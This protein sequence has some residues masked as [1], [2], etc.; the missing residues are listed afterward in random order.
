MVKQA[1]DFWNERRIRNKSEMQ[2]C[3]KNILPIIVE[4]AT[5]EVYCGGANDISNK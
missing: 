5:L 1:T 3:L 2:A 4:Y